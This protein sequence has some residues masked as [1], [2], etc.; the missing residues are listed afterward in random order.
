MPDFSLKVVS[1]CCFLLLVFDSFF[2]SGLMC[3]SEVLLF[4]FGFPT[5]NHKN[6]DWP[7]TT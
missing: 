2:L 1:F 7:D 5:N 3:E 6:V 4:V